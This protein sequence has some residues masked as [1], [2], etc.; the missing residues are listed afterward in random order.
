MTSAFSARLRGLSLAASAAALL[1]VGTAVTPAIAAPA[2]AELP[3]TEL[4]YSG[5]PSGSLGWGSSRIS[6]DLNGDGRGDAVVGD[7]A[8][9]RAGV[10]NV[11]TAYVILADDNTVAGDIE[12]FA[13]SHAVRIDGPAVAGAGLGWSV[14]CL[15][16]VNGDGIDDVI[17]S[18]GTVAFSTAYVVFGSKTFSDVD[19]EVL[20]TRGF[21]ISN[22][23]GPDGDLNLRPG[24]FGYSV[25][26]VGD[27]NDDG[28]AD[29]GIGDLLADPNDRTNSGRVWVVSGSRSVRNVDVAVDASR[30][31]ATI[32]GAAG[33]DRLTTVSSVGDMNGDGVDDIAV[34]AYVAVPWGAD[35]K[36]TGAAYVVYGK[37]DLTG[38]VADAGNLGDTG[39]AIYG[40]KRMG[41]RLGQSIAPAGDVNGDGLA[42]LLVGADGVGTY[43]ARAGGAA[44]VY[45]SRSA[46]TVFTAPGEKSYA[47][48]A[49]ADGDL[50]FSCDSSNRVSRGY[51][52]DGG[53]AN[54][55]VGFSVA[56]LGDV[57]GDGVPDFALGAQRL[58]AWLVFG[59]PAQTKTQMLGTATS[60][61]ALHLPSKQG[62]SVGAAGDLDGNGTPDF[63]AAGDGFARAYLLGTLKTSLTLSAP[64]T[65][66]NG[67]TVTY[68]AQAAASVQS[69]TD[70]LAGT[71]AFTAN[72]AAIAGCEAVA[73]SGAAAADCTT[74][75]S[76]AA[77]AATIA[78][79]FTSASARFASASAQATVTVAKSKSWIDEPTLSTATTVFGAGGV[80]VRTEV[81][82]ATA[83][84]VEFTSAGAVVGTATVGADGA[85]SLVLPKTL[86]AGTHT[87]VARFTGTDRVLASSRV[88]ADRALVVSKA[89]SAV[90]KPTLSKAS[91]IFGAGTVTVSA[92]VTSPEA[93]TVT[94]RNGTTTLGT[95]KVAANGTATL[96][97]PKTQAVGSY[98]ISATF[99]GTANVAASAKSATATLKVTKAALVAKPKIAVPAVAKNTAPVMT[100]TLGKLNNGAYPTGKLTVTIGS[101]SRTVTVTAANKGVVRVVFGT[102]ISKNTSVSATLQG[103]ATMTGSAKVTATATIR[104]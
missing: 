17:V 86:A 87:L 73:V 3:V 51:W 77:G 93:G 22:S 62:I 94:F 48:F 61:A 76:E 100:V 74:K 104:K 67:T 15:G 44:V 88:I 43:G 70:A 72:G 18:S 63:I 55:K 30:V 8:W 54:G 16:D 85:A 92:K 2:S 81:L 19:L 89:K 56:G 6:C 29:I 36:A 53:T 99:G 59:D 7:Q 9:D 11:G 12:S 35:V 84:T 20:G 101:S 32:D 21:A 4:V 37:K 95:A 39:F 41:D 71:V 50:D 98:A 40:P 42:D 24:N 103:T 69:Q 58:G 82:G 46:A 80:T 66:T 5:Q 33:N 25:G 52:I 1:L 102:K 96:T 60:A 10:N 45:G 31:I 14:S 26:A 65:A 90:A 49:C 28:L 23:G 79:T 34:S 57:N 91:A 13:T 64:A 97:L 78:A 75:V 83:G 68:S 27:V 47:V 38:L